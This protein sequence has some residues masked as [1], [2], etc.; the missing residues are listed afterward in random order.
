MKPPRER[1]CGSCPYRQDVP[2]GVWHPD[3]Y[4]KLIP[5]DRPTAE[6]PLNLF[7][8][9]QQDGHLCAGWVGCHDMD[10]SMAVRLAVLSGDLDPEDLEA[11]LNY[12][13]PVPL[14]SSGMEAAA[15]GLAE[16]PNPPSRAKSIM[17]NLRRKG[18]VHDGP[19]TG[20][21]RSSGTQR[22]GD[23]E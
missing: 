23:P 1:P 3:E 7:A 4:A 14:W 8:C 20:E 13:S 19:G 18:L 21:L 10:E 2:G 9:H 22:S 6:Q 16:V 15:H 12:E 17:R 5:Y 11:V